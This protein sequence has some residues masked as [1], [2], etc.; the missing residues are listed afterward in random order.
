MSLLTTASPWN[1]G[2]TKKRAPTMR[3][4]I[5]KMAHDDNDDA[6]DSIENF[7][8]T[9]SSNRPEN[10][11]EKS[12]MINESRNAR[13]NDLLNKMDSLNVD[14]DGSKL[15]DFKPPPSAE[16]TAQRRTNATGI[17]NRDSF[18]PEIT[19]PDELLPQNA[20]MQPIPSF[21]QQAQKRQIP[22]KSMA[23]YGAN[24][25]GITQFSNYN[26][27]YDPERLINPVAN[28]KPYYSKMGIGATSDDKLME[29]LNYMIHLLEEQQHEKTN[30]VME[31][32]ILYTFLG[33]FVIFMS[34][35]FARAGKYVR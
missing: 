23:S 29:K 5:K 11:I 3:K 20:M 33:V 14:N 12:Y 16:L 10:T 25:I 9:T 31:E 1:S 19:S 6:D 26:T 35:S 15:V 2:N 18:T 27:T 17:Q 7:E 24:D 30:N 4:T 34:D 22:V 28:N 8:S 32:F 13:V 21:F